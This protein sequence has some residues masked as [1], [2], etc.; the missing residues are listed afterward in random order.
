MDA[1]QEI[2]E[3]IDQIIEGKV[4]PGAGWANIRSLKD[5]YYKQYNSQSWNSFVGKRFEFIIYAIL[6]KSLSNAP[7]GMKVLKEQELKEDEV[8]FRKLA[9]QY[10]DHLIFPDADSALVSIN[11][12]NPWQSEV[13][14]IF[15]C[16]TSLRERIAQSCY[17]KLK[18]LIWHFQ[19]D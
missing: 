3:I 8:L 18:F 14:A 11:H 6:A 9:V 10:G 2:Q 13:I 19:L 16:K 15:S 7:N 1:K 4:D 12:E 17:W 5:T